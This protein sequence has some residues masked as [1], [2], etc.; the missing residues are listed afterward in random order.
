MIYKNILESD[1]EAVKP[2]FHHGSSIFLKLKQTVSK[3]YSHFLKK[4]V[5]F[6]M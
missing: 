3:I 5:L 4:I 6:H 2:L 1:D